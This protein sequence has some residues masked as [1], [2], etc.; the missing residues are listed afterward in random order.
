MATMEDMSDEVVM[1]V[2]G[3]VPP[4]D[5]MRHVSLVSKRFRAFILASL[6]FVAIDSS[7]NDNNVQY[8][9]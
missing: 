1:A 9:Q 7:N 2:L 8:V 3:H 6:F 5:L 4:M